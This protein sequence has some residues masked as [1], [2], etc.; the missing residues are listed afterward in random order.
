MSTTECSCC[1]CE[2][3]DSAEYPYACPSCGAIYSGGGKC[4]ACK[5][6]LVSTFTGYATVFVCSGNRTELGRRCGNWTVMKRELCECGSTM[7]RV[8]VASMFGVYQCSECRRTIFDF[9]N[10]RKMIDE[11]PDDRCRCKVKG[12]YHLIYHYGANREFVCK[13]GFSQC[14]N[15][16]RSQEMS[17]LICPKC[18]RSFSLAELFEVFNG[19][20]MLEHSPAYDSP[21]YRTLITHRVPNFSLHT[22]ALIT[23]EFKKLIE[24][25]KQRFIDGCRERIHVDELISFG[26]M[27]RAITRS[28]APVKPRGVSDD[29]WEACVI[30]MN[31]FVN[32]PY[33]NNS[34]L[35]EVFDRYEEYRRTNNRELL[36]GS[37]VVLGRCELESCNGKIVKYGSSKCYCDG[38]HHAYCSK[39]ARPI[40]ESSTTHECK[41]EDVEMVASYGASNDDPTGHRPCP[42]C[43]VMCW[44]EM[45]CSTVWCK[46]CHNFFDIITGR[47][48]PQRPTHSAD[49]IDYLNSIGKT[50]SQEVTRHLNEEQPEGINDGRHHHEANF[51][52]V[53]INIQQITALSPALGQLFS[54]VT[55]LD[56]LLEGEEL[57]NRL[58]DEAMRVVIGEGG[59]NVIREI[60]EIINETAKSLLL[61]DDLFEDIVE[62]NTFGKSLLMSFTKEKSKKPT[63]E[64]LKI[65][66][67]EVYKLIL[68]SY[69]EIPIFGKSI[70]AAAFGDNIKRFICSMNGGITT[71]VQKLLYKDASY[72]PELK[73]DSEARQKAISPTSHM[74]CQQAFI[75]AY[76]FSPMVWTSFEGEDAVD[77]NAK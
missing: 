21:E 22:S 56:G 63:L 16:I 6:Q 19:V 34:E 7:E 48:L 76:S 61:I 44:R 49:Y 11:F 41:Q 42:F 29:E 43:G 28:R 66:E 38:C 68:A 36:H 55:H 69:R 23:D 77:I 47:K 32:N 67:S 9:T 40:N 37:E 65:V 13:C 5:K 18:K 54:M 15:C 57:F 1:C 4:E 25:R 33:A 17:N 52:G 53:N 35:I 2:C 31:E 50:L 64:S 45:Y 74:Y 59:A 10:E 30:F 75:L 62:F 14:F 51:C 24:L 70:Y 39:C 20:S 26:K 3:G 58:K 72:M 73:I 8:R 27:A 46:E 12:N 60:N 71:T